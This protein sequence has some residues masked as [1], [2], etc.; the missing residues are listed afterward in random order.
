MMK[1]KFFA[2]TYGRGLWSSD[3]YNPIECFQPKAVSVANLWNVS[4][5]LQWQTPSVAPGL[6]YEW[7]INTNV[8]LPTT[9]Q[10]TTNTSVDITGLTPSTNYYL[11]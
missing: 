11:L 9:T 5:T 10:T 1:T 8:N 7:G 2:A 3:L 6:G 4:M